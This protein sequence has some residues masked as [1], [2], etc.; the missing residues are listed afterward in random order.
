[1]KQILL[2]ISFT[3]TLL[4][5]ASSQNI[6]IGTTTPL[7]QLH[8]TGT[9]LLTGVTNNDSYNKV[10]VQ[11]NIGLLFWRNAS[12]IGDQNSWLL[13]GNTGTTPTNS[14]LGTTDNSRLVIKTNSAERMTVLGNGNVGIGIIDPIAKLEINNSISDTHLKLSGANPSLQLYA[15]HNSESVARIGFAT[16]NA[17]FVP[18]SK[19][20][21]FIIGTITRTPAGVA[22]DLILGAGKNAAQNNGYEAMRITQTFGKGRIG[23]GTTTPTAQFHTTDTVR[24]ENIKQG[25]GNY[26]VIDAQGYIWRSSLAPASKTANRTDSPNYSEE[27]LLLKTEIDKLKSEIVIL[28]SQLKSRKN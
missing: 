1:M 3:I 19:I 13:T 2:V 8:T 23:I 10:L 11:D 18:T 9:V 6:G 15:D 28:K 7:A 26:L 14:Y 22:G 21:D 4:Q 24:H 12:T 5:H 25:V 17:A 27:F 16:T 20:G